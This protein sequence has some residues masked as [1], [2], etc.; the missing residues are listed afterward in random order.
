MTKIRL[1]TLI[2]CIIGTLI[3]TISTGMAIEKEMCVPMGTI[4]LKAP[5]GV[6]TKRS[7][8]SFPH[9]VHFGYSCVTCHH[10]WETSSPITGC[11]VSGCHD[12]KESP[13][14]SKDKKIKAN[15]PLYYKNAFH[16][17][18]LGCHKDLKKQ[19]KA[20]EMKKGKIKEKIPTAGPTACISC[21]PKG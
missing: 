13:L 15:S 10:K 14:K 1:R 3:V 9:T 8:V 20:L 17:K 11:Q 4:T 21:H 19:A 18:C 6:E 16:K 7:A 12:V 5:S 2:V